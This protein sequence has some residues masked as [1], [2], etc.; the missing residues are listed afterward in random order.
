MKLIAKV[1]SVLSEILKAIELV[2]KILDEIS[3]VN[4]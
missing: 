3:N 2:K 1:L 4:L